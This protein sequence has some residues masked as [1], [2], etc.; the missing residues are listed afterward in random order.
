MAT[1]A[2]ADGVAAVASVVAAAAVA[3][4]EV[5]AVAALADSA[6]YRAAVLRRYIHLGIRHR[7]HGK[8]PVCCD[9]KFDVRGHQVNALRMVQDGFTRLDG[10]I[11]DDLIQHVWQR[12]FQYRTW[13]FRLR[14]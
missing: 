11:A 14:R 9:A 6:A 10:R 8:R 3:A 5:P 12:F 4:A 2:A 7:S 1:G 13:G